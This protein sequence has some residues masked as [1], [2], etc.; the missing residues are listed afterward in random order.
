VTLEASEG[1]NPPPLL[2][3]NVEELA[4]RLRVLELCEVPDS[5]DPAQV[6]DVWDQEMA[7][8]AGEWMELP[9]DEQDRYRMRALY[10]P[11]ILGQ[12]ARATRGGGAVAS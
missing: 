7:L 2:P 3:E 9:R 6:F 12:V 4:M 8:A 10:V 5:V 1:A 11:H